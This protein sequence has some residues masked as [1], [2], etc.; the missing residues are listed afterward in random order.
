ML[1]VAVST[2]GT[3][4]SWL[5]LKI[6]KIIRNPTAISKVAEFLMQP[7]CAHAKIGYKK[8][9]SELF[10]DVGVIVYELAIHVLPRA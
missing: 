9:S 2:I 7:A 8:L 3:E 1:V 10:A 5:N 6:C 4:I